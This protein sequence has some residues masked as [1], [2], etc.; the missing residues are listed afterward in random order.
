[1]NFLPAFLQLLSYLQRPPFNFRPSSP[2]LQLPPFNFYPLT[3]I[4]QL[5]SFN[6]LASSLQ[7]PSFNYL[8][9]PPFL[10][11]LSGRDHDILPGAQH[12]GPL[13]SF[14]SFI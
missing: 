7:L 1:L 8:Q 4:L 6:F 2:I 11:S 14:P 9:L 3:S 5:L 13:P 12:G 10:P